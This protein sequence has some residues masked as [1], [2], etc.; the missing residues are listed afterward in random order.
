MLQTLQED[1]KESYHLVKNGHPMTPSDEFNI[2]WKMFSFCLN[3]FLQISV[4][5]VMYRKAPPRVSADGDEET[6]ALLQNW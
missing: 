3:A 5:F 2:V 1:P 4:Q 6:A